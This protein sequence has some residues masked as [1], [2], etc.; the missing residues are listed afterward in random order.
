MRVKLLMYCGLA[1]DR[2][3]FFHSHSAAGESKPLCRSDYLSGRIQRAT[4]Q[5]PASPPPPPP[6]PPSSLPHTRA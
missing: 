4:N 1:V 3:F 6:P 5:T 2:A